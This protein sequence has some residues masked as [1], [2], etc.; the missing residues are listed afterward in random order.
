MEHNH[1]TNQVQSDPFSSENTW[2]VH[3][4]SLAA[5]GLLSYLHLAPLVA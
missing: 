2:M 4:L 5:V 1:T 3:C